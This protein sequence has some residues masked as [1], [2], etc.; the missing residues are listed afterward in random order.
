MFSAR[1]GLLGAKAREWGRGVIFIQEVFVFEW[2]VRTDDYLLSV[3][4]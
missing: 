3:S 4:L 1:Q 2:D